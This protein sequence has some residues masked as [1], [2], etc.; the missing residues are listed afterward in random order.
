[1]H[2]LCALVCV[3]LHGC[4]L[5]RGEGVASSRPL[6]DVCLY[7][8][9]ICVCMHVL[10]FTCLYLCVCIYVF[11][12]GMC[13]CIYVSYVFVCMYTRPTIAHRTRPNTAYSPRPVASLVTKKLGRGAAPAA[14]VGVCGCVGVG[15]VSYVFVR[16]VDGCL[17]LD[18]FSVIT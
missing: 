15:C 5:C 3:V 8:C 14:V 13:V 9:V 2:S 16:C 18:G 7:L 6:L 1:M 11:V 12:C 10:V 17:H 4:R